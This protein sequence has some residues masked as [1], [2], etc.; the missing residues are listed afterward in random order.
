M[1]MTV[2]VRFRR[3]LRSDINTG[4]SFSLCVCRRDFFLVWMRISAMFD[5]RFFFEIAHVR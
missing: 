2:N 3:R 4:V 5:A 1:D